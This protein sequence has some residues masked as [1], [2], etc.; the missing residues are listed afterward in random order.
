MNIPDYN[1]LTGYVKT[2]SICRGTESTISGNNMIKAQQCY[3]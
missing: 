1:E 2:N 3:S